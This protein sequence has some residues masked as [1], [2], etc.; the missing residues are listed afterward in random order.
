MSLPA[1]RGTGRT[2]DGGPAGRRDPPDLL[3]GLPLRGLGPTVVSGRIA[4]V[5]IDP[6]DANVWYVASAFGGL[7]K[8]VNR[9]VS[10]TPIFDRGGSFTL[11][12]VAIDPHDSRVIWLGT[13]ENTSQR[14]AQFGD[15]VY[16]STDAG[17]TWMRVGLDASEHIGRI[18]IDPRDSRVVYV[19]AQG[20]LFSAGGQRG[21]YKT[22]DGGATW[23][24]VLFVSDDTGISDI[25]FHPRNPDIVYAGSYQRRRHVGQMI[26]GGPDGG[27]FRS[28][29]AGRT[30]TK[31][32]RGLPPGDVG[33]IALATDPRAP[34]RVYALVDARSG[35]DR[36]L[37]DPPP[38]T[39]DDGVGFYRSEDR[40]NHWTRMSRYRG[41]GAAYYFELFVD[42]RE[43]DTIW[44]MNTRLQRSRDGGRT[45]ADVGAEHGSGVDA[46][47]VDHH[48]V[49]F[50]PTNRDHLLDGNDGG[51]Y[52]SYDNG[53][54]WRFFANLPVTQFYRVSI[55][56]EQPFYS[57][58]GGTQDNFSLCGPSRTA[59][60]L[61][62]RSSDWFI[63]AGGDGFTVR[64]DRGAPDILYASSQEGGL[65]RFDRRTG[66]SHSIRPVR[67][68]RAAPGTR[69]GGG[70]EDADRIN[71]DA[72]YITSVHAPTRLYWAS[73]FVYRSDDRG[74][75]WRRISP[76][77]TRQL[78]WRTLPI[79]GRVW[80]A[81]A[82]ALHEST[83]ALST[84]VALDESPLDDGLLYA[85]TDDGLLQVTGDG[86]R[87]WRRIADFPGVPRWTYVS[88]VFASPH[89]ADTVFVALN[90]WQNGDYQP[91]LVMSTDRGR[92]WANITGNLPP[93]HDVWTVAQDRRDP[94]LLFVGTEFGLFVSLD[95]GGHWTPLGGGMPPA[96]VR[97]L[98]IQ[99]RE[100][101]LVVATFGRG[102]YVLDDYSALR[103]IAPT[104]L[105]RAVY[106]FPIR[107]AFA[108]ELRGLAP[109]GASGLGP[110]AGND[111]RPNPPIGALIDY[112]VGRGEPDDAGLALSITDGGNHLVRRVQVDAA[113]G[114]HRAVWDLRGDAAF[115]APAEDVEPDPEAAEADADARGAGVSAPGGE[116]ADQRADAAQARPRGPDGDRREARQAA[117]APPPASGRRPRAVL[118]SPGIYQVQL[119]RERTG[120]V[121]PVGPVQ[122][123]EVRALPVEDT[124]P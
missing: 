22:T 87:S 107:R 30:W 100:D 2:A 11:C 31:L 32:T 65:S 71:W 28:T 64:H 25:A 7:W 49:A 55:G 124:E 111:T 75:S 26:G 103:A 35:P 20:P 43:A 5:A 115:G 21:L 99:S 121:T 10:F 45:W 96:Q 118:V 56:N 34:N 63:I 92:H 36:S 114:L 116:P 19:A 62:I 40:G 33:R 94:D 29:D 83:T 59:S 76:D 17:A 113:P 97:D 88:D 68:R 14:S 6:R 109:D 27:L 58:C 50:D 44:S 117:P 95:R 73:N 89:D 82:I 24:R 108:F 38:P 12:C 60:V 81:D 67:A 47:H 119:V 70:D 85:G 46:V 66:R 8:T 74:D 18:L 3:A 80:P 61:G 51:L 53:R 48:V 91:Y 15:G 9:G 13:G 4:D 77:L 79:M 39:V 57:V 41:G 16:K 123:V 106:L 37:S 105:A 101:D 54:T 42:P 78:D 98:Q 23:R 90:N 120:S 112:Y 72:P 110:M 122:T 1:C 102:L 104:V 86:G 69:P 84:I 93:R 52:E